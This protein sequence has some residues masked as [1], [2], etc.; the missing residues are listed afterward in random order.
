M[1]GLAKAPVSKQTLDFE[2]SVVLNR[3]FLARLGAAEFDDL[4]SRLESARE[5]DFGDGN[6][7]F[8][9]ALVSAG[10]KDEATRAKLGDYD[11][12]ILAEERELARGRGDFRF[13][14]FQWLAL[15]FTELYLD[16]LTDQPAALRRKL[17]E[18][19]LK[20]MARGALPGTMT[21]FTEDDLR[22]IAFFMATGSGKT[23]LPH[24]H[25]RQLRHYL[26]HGAHPEML[27]NRADGRREW[28]NILLIKP[29]EGLSEQHL[30]ELRES[31]VEC[32]RFSRGIQRDLCPGRGC[33]QRRQAR[34][35]D[36]RLRQDHPLRLQLPLFPRRRSREGFRG[37]ETLRRH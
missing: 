29:D 10:L 23:L 18:F 4:R 19:F 14:Y 8:F 25:I 1:A 2:R 36:E 26:A 15:L 9:R 5:G 21:E 24:S 12:R 7:F 27:A 28:D 34:G 30:R 33:G 3:Y 20:E 16:A 6:S 35:A 37:T 13:K 22:R 17:N 31:G 11:R 32:G